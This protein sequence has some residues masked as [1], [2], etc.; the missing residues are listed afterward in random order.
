MKNTTLLILF[1]I[2][3]P[4]LGYS[5]TPTIT[6]F[7][8]LSAEIGT[9]VT[10][11]GTNF[12]T[13]PSNNIV[14]FGATKANVSSSTST[15]LN[16][17]VPEG[18]TY[19]KI[20]IVNNNSIVYSNAFFTPSFS[21]CGGPNVQANSWQNGIG[22]YTGSTNQSGLTVGDIDGDGK[23][24]ILLNSYTGGA[25]DSL[26]IFRNTSS[27]GIINSSS[28]SPKVG[29][30]IGGS[31]NKVILAD[32]DVDG[33]LDIIVSNGGMGTTWTFRV[34][35]NTSSPGSITTTSLSGPTTF[36]LANLGYPQKI[37]FGDI[38]KDGK[39]DLAIYT[40]GNNVLVKRNTSTPGTI[41]TSS[42]ATD[43]AYP[44]IGSGGSIDDIA[45]GD[46]DGDEKADI[47]GSA[48]GTIQILRSTS[49]PGSISFAS[50]VSFT[51]TG[52]QTKVGL[53]DFN[54]D[55]KTDII[56]QLYTFSGTFRIL[57]NTSTPGII[58]AS[59][60]ATG[61]SFTGEF[62]SIANLD[63]DNRP[64]LIST[65]KVFLNTST[66]GV[67][68]ASTFST[69]ITLGN[70]TTYDGAVGDIDADGLPDLIYSNSSLPGI[71]IS[72]RVGTTTVPTPEICL[73]SVDTNSTH[74]IVYWDKTT[75]IGTSVSSFVVHRETTPNNYIPIDTV[76]IDS[77]SEFHDIGFGADPNITTY[78]YK[79]ACIDTCGT[80]SDLSPYHNTVFVTGNG[81][82]TF[83]YNLYSIESAANPVNNYVLYRD[84]LSDNNWAVIGLTSGTQ[85]VLNDP[86]YATYATTGR[87]RVE[88]LWGI[89]CDPTR[90]TIN[91]TRS[92]I[93]SSSLIGIN[94]NILNNLV[95]VFPNPANTSITVQLSSFTKM[96][97][98]SINNSLGEIVSKITTTNQTEIIPVE[99]LKNGVYTISIQTELGTAY[100][101]LVIQ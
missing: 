42:F 94:E 43:I 99:K 62:M 8:P 88:T 24:D 50:F 23:T 4:L 80:I 21:F 34:F 76:S 2:I 27:A 18:A 28:L 7:N 12:S 17:T 1:V 92:N 10:I 78:R 90:T 95:T 81:S 54:L 45:V 39:P 68:D 59:S 25:Q 9:T 69:E 96:S 3:S 72:K 46:I 44:I 89:T 29:F 77:L 20:S 57:K 98:I 5:Q 52:N 22:F 83:N 71:S 100:K 49:S 61:V 86:S 53:A 19:S 64:D 48:A 85:T 73:V 93:K 55:G 70:I 51:T 67:I 91:T 32:I 15:T 26:F 37:A 74:N 58:N 56:Q 47:V 75:F 79:L 36:T 66:S 11:T 31:S 41:N 65:D 38:D 16:V 63:G 101:K 30:A 13:T 33:K 6:S 87:W 82:G 40:S 14:Y 84:N 60:F 97:M 35:R